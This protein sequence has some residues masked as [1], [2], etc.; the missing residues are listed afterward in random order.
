[1]STPTDPFHAAGAAR[2]RTRW[3]AVVLLSLATLWL[4]HD[5][6]VAFRVAKQDFSPHPADPLPPACPAG[7]TGEL[8]AVR[9]A[10]DP[11]LAGW[12]VA[13]KNGATV[14]IL[15]GS[16][17]TAATMTPEI[18]LL[19]AAGFGVLAYDSPG[20]GS[21]DGRVRWGDGERNALRRAVDWL[22]EQS[23]PPGNRIGALGFSMG[24]L[25]LTCAASRD[26]R[27]AAVVVAASPAD[28][29]EQILHEAGRD[30]WIKWPAVRL[31]T[32]YYRGA[33]RDDPQPRECIGAI[34]PRPILM[35]RGTDDRVVPAT[36]T[37]ALYER[38]QEPKEL[39]LVPGAGHGNYSAVAPEAYRQRLV[40]FFTDALGVGRPFPPSQGGRP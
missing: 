31:A 36:T 14:I 26:P 11:A 7:S 39:W 17:A 5:W 40:R 32:L 30:R 20:A 12:Y 34:S 24:G 3:L 29:L 27:L 28:L 23:G 25:V 16:D 22:T 15:H 10:G 33:P 8:R 21:S 9:L 37:L 18:C 38:A 2:S 13:P 35:I 4:V 1:M 6:S 19:A